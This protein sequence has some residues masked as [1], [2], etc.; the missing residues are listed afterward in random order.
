[1]GL[2]DAYKVYAYNSERDCM[3]LLMFEKLPL[4]HKFEI[5]NS[6]GGFPL[7][8]R[9]TFAPFVIRFAFLLKKI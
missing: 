6:S 3:P 4:F 2:E 9:H 5:T 1:M 8:Y 7:M